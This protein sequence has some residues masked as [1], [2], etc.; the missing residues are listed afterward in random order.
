M[1]EVN[2][3]VQ[4]AIGKYRG[5]D[6]RYSRS[7]YSTRMRARVAL[8]I[9]YLVF[10]TGLELE[11][12]LN[13][14][15]EALGLA[16]LAYSKYQ[17][18]V[19]SS[20][21]LRQDLH[22]AIL[23]YMTARVQD[24]KKMKIS[25]EEKM[26][27]LLLLSRSLLPISYHDAE[28]V[29]NDAHEVASDIDVETSYEIGLFSPLAESASL[30][31][32]I[33][34]RKSIAQNLAVII[35]DA[36]I[37]LS[38]YDHFPWRGVIQSLALLNVSVALAAA[39]RWEDENLV[40]RDTTLHPILQTGLSRHEL[41]A[42]QI[43]ALL[44]LI[45][46]LDEEFMVAISDQAILEN[47]P[48][49]MTQ[50]EYLARDEL[51]R[52]GK[53]SREK[54]A[55]KLMTAL[56]EVNS[57]YWTSHL[58]R[59]A[60][61]HD[62]TRHQERPATAEKSSDTIDA[63]AEYHDLFANLLLAMEQPCSVEYL[64]STIRKFLQSSRSG[65]IRDRSGILGDLR[66]SISSRNQ[67]NYLEA[68]SQSESSY[69]LGYEIA[70]ELVRC[71]KEWQ[72]SLSVIRWRQERLLGVITNHL[73]EF[74]KWISF[75][76]DH[77][78]SLLAMVD[79]P[80]NQ[81]TNTLFGAIESHVDEFDSRTLYG[82]IGIVSGFCIP[83][84]NAQVLVRFSNQLLLRI[85]PTDRES[86]D[87]SDI[88]NDSLNGV[89]RFIYALMSDIDVRIRWRA[90]HALR[91][92]VNLGDTTILDKIIGLYDKTSEISFRRPDVPFYWLAT[93]LWL[94]IAVDRISSETPLAVSPH[95]T[96]LFNH[97]HI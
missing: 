18:E 73:L 2:F 66:K 58:L 80:N 32:S 65:R 62:A 53:G 41:T 46:D 21:A 64:R 96:W 44:P 52:F 17:V 14:V 79:I 57:G 30:T 56:G 71:L 27:E 38:G 70:L 19:W 25:A 1:N 42:K 3:A 20:L 23:C 13:N 28:S 69:L 37:R 84:E 75:G 10:I 40:D 16:S 12:L 88:P 39:S 97:C 78:Q 7:P 26:N 43:T 9:T 4:K 76:E 86:W 29:F 45:D 85:H 77:L 55:Y 68:L 81:I 93:R 51:Q 34:Q 89:A 50:V 54:I 60:S 87:I 6:Y 83:E 8:S 31:M 82:L 90:V 47:S 5:Q 91:R 36:G 94:M 63:S 67:V 15:T 33:D 92:F 48:S 35:S 95:H 49:R 59:T 11:N 24:T 22:P 72:A 61:F 74:S